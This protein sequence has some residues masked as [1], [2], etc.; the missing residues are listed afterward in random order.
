MAIK[1]LKE[2]GENLQKIMK[3][4]LANQNLMKYVYYTDKDPLAQPDLEK[5]IITHE[6]YQNLVKI[7]PRLVPNTSAKSMIAINVSSGQKNPS[8]REFRDVVLEIEV[9]VPITQWII[10]SD[11]LRPFLIMGEIQESLEGKRINGLGKIEGG[12]FDFNF[13]SEEMTSYKMYF[14][15]TAYD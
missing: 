15:I 10:K 13:V 1:N 11:N 2:M 14:Y 8:N 6:I 7:I 4:L 12:D 9:F 5:A 3:C